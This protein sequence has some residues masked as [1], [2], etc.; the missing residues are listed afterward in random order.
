MR[1]MGST[2]RDGHGT[3]AARLLG[4][5]VV[6]LGLLSMHG[7]TSTHHAAA[8]VPVP[9][10][11]AHRAPQSPHGHE[12][13]DPGDGPRDSPA[14]AGTAAAIGH[15]VAVA[16]GLPGLVCDAGCP[17]DAAVLCLAVLVV[18]CAVAVLTATGRRRAGP[19]RSRRPGPLAG[20]P[21][22]RRSPSTPDPVK[23]LCVSRT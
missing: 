9:S 6:L 3:A 19:H 4:L 12:H 21:A 13:H 11:V 1:S 16:V 18:A 23:D 14:T 22:R 15:A 7:L 20:R 17:P 2:A 5:L 10:A 8:A